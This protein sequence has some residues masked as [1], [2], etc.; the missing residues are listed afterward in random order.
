MDLCQPELPSLI[1]QYLIIWDD[2][3]GSGPDAIMTWHQIIIQ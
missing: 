1:A 2:S 3:R